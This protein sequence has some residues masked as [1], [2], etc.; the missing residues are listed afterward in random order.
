MHLKRHTI[1]CNE[2][3]IFCSVFS[4]DFDDRLNPNFHRF[5]ILCLLWDTPSDP[6]ILVFDNYQTCP[7]PLNENAYKFEKRKQLNQQINV[8]LRN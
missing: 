3:V 7:E 1:L 5:D 8:L 6:R 4:C 2:G